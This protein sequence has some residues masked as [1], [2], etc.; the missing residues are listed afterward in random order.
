MGRIVTTVKIQ[1][2]RHPDTTELECSALV[3]SGAA[4]MVL[5]KAWKHRLGELE[6][7]R[8]VEVELGDQTRVRGE[9]CGPVKIKVEGFPQIF[10]EVLF[11][12]MLEQDNRGFEPLLGYVVLEQSQAAVDMVKHRLTYVKTV[13]L[14]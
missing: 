2:A 9:I 12:E 6:L 14:K 13:D 3:D 5:P 11:V 4:Y 7:A 8:E 1:N 10:S